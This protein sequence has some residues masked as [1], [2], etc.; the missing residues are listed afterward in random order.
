AVAAVAGLL[1]EAVVAH[2]PV[3]ALAGVEAPRRLRAGGGQR[4]FLG[5]ERPGVGQG[6]AGVADAVQVHEDEVEALE[7]AGQPPAPVGGE[8]RAPGVVAALAEEL[9][10]EAGLQVAAGRAA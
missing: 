6:A 9:E 8:G 5:L 3:A 4:R 1:A 10:L 2:V 7:P